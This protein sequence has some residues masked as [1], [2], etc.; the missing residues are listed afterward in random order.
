[1][2]A[3]NGGLFVDLHRAK[4]SESRGMMKV[5]ETGKVNA[6]TPKKSAAAPFFP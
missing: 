6:P 3:G 1:L 2:R 4:F 5:E